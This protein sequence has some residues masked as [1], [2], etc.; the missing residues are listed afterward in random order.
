[1]RNEC[2]RAWKQ[3]MGKKKRHFKMAQNMEGKEIREKE[4]TIRF[5]K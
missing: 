1:M 3:I 4:K 2:W 5:E